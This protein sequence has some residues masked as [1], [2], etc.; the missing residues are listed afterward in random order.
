[1]KICVRLWTFKGTQL[2]AIREQKKPLSTLQPVDPV[3]PFLS[4]TASQTWSHL[5][6]RYTES[7]PKMWYLSLPDEEMEETHLLV[8]VSWIDGLQWADKVRT[9]DWNG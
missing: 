6:P 7:K 1:M 5:W 3:M 8:E 4:P 9:L 2:G